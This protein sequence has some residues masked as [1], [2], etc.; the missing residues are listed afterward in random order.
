MDSEFCSLVGLL[1]LYLRKHP[2]GADR[3]RMF[4]TDERLLFDTDDVA[5]LAG[6]SVGHVQKLCKQG[7]LPYIPG[8]PHKF[9]IGPL[10]NALE[11]MQTGGI[12]GRKTKRRISK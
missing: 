4:L 5:R 10:R 11:Q 7:V 3:L 9:M 8:N 6:W 12:Y 1:Q 2:D